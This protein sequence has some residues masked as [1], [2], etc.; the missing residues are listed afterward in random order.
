MQ[1]C[2]ENFTTHLEFIAVVLTHRNIEL[3]IRIYYTIKKINFREDYKE[4]Y[5]QSNTLVKG[6]EHWQLT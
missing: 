1:Q 2:V 5:V 4:H 6:I 3:A